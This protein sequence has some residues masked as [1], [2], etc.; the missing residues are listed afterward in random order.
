VVGSGASDLIRFFQEGHEP[1]HVWQSSISQSG[2][3][4]RD[5]LAHWT[6]ENRA[7]TEALTAI[8]ASTREVYKSR[9]L[10][11]PHADQAGNDKGAEGPNSPSKQSALH[12]AEAAEFIAVAADGVAR[13]GSISAAATVLI[14]AAGTT[15]RSG[16]IHERIIQGLWFLFAIVLTAFVN[17]VLDFEIKR[18]LEKAQSPQE[19]HKIAKQAA[20]QATKDETDA[21]RFRYVSKGTLTVRRSA[22]ATAPVIGSLHFPQVVEVIERRPDFTLV[23][24]RGDDGESEVRGWVF[25]R[26]LKRFD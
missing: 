18:R 22:S 11:R 13:S 23:A 10:A 7:L 3:A 17:S 26:Y 2:S 6:E 21:S 5:A 14:E 24:W 19:E 15:A 8:E 12:Q 9:D 20:R 4:L 1:S 25:S 16:A